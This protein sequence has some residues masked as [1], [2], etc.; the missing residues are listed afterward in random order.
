MAVEYCD[1]PRTRVLYRTIW[2]G[3]IGLPAVAESGF[4]PA[5]KLLPSFLPVLAFTAALSAGA[6]AEGEEFKPIEDAMK[7]AHKAP[8]GTPKVSDKIIDGTVSDEDLKKTLELYKAMA[9]TKPPKG[10]AAAFKEKVAKLITAT[11]DVIAKKDGAGAAY[12]QAVNCKACHS[13]H[14]AD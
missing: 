14:K 6:F 4:S 5:M 11:E 12:K 7:F 2:R 10:E 3:G 1:A 13:D 9:D 8:K